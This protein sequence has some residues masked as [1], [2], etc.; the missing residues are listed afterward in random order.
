MAYSCND[1]RQH[2][3]VGVAAWTRMKMLQKKKPIHVMLGTGDQVR[4]RF[5]HIRAS[6]P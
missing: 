4:Q 3:K 6:R 5:S 2:P 1:Q